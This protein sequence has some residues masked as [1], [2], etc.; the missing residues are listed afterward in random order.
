MTETTEMVN[1]NPKLFDVNE[2]LEKVIKEIM[3]GNDPLEILKELKNDTKKKVE[4]RIHD[5]AIGVVKDV[6]KDIK[7]GDVST[8]ANDEFAEEVIKFGKEAGKAIW[9]YLQNEDFTEEDLKKALLETDIKKIGK[10]FLA[11]AGLDLDEIKEYVK[12][13]QKLDHSAVA[14][15]CFQEAYKILMDSLNDAKLKY[16]ERL[17]VEK[18]CAETVRMIKDYRT[19]MERIISDYFEA[20]HETME[21]SF[22]QMDKAILANDSDGFIAGNVELQKLLKYD[23]QFTN[24]EEFDD[25]MNSDEAFRL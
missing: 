14:Y 11:A 7:I 4:D 15:V 23:V 22:L 3:D 25:L 24:Q 6:I 1:A 16:E 13:L 2:V 18:E 8:L 19:N 12:E 17:I 10:E 9:K 5:E 20:H 21:N